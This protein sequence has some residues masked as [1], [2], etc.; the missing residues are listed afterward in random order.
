M[1]ATIREVLR[2]SARTTIQ[3]L[4]IELTHRVDARAF[5]GRAGVALRSGRA[6]ETEAEG[7]RGSDCGTISVAATTVG[8]A[9]VGAT[10]GTSAAAGAATLPALA[11]VTRVIGVS[12]GTAGATES[13]TSAS[14]GF[15]SGGA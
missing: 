9:T 6:G 4:A 10:T 7:T 2:A 13:L 12:T 11:I 3:F 1:D 15:G 5:G 14:A 8:A